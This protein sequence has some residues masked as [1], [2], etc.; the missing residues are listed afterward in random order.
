[1]GAVAGALK[2]YCCCSEENDGRYRLMR[3]SRLATRCSA[4]VPRYLMK[5][6]AEEAEVVAGIATV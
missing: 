3:A 2:A 1:M 6:G 4:S 5:A